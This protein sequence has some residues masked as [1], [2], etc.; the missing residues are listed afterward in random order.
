MTSELE[1]VIY[2]LLIGFLILKGPKLLIEIVTVIGLTVMGLLI[3]LVSLIV[4]GTEWV[5]DRICG[6]RSGDSPQEG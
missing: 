6:S 4:L 3:G 1:I 5:R 2:G